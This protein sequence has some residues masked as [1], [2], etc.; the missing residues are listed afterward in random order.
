MVN[1]LKDPGLPKPQ[2]VFEPIQ[3]NWSTQ[4]SIEGR[5]TYTDLGYRGKAP[6]NTDKPAIVVRTGYG[7]IAA[8]FILKENISKEEWPE[9]ALDAMARPETNRNGAHRQIYGDLSKT[10][11]YPFPLL[12]PKLY[13]E[14]IYETTKLTC[15]AIPI[16]Q[17]RKDGVA[18]TKGTPCK[19]GDQITYSLC[20]SMPCNCFAAQRVHKDVKELE[21]YAP[22][23][24]SFEMAKDFEPPG[25]R[26]KAKELEQLQRQ[27]RSAAAK[28]GWETR[29]RKAAET[30]AEAA[31]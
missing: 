23:R 31:Q 16:C 1:L 15:E 11:E 14:D 8:T 19:P 30:A 25:T 3:H 26:D 28:K 10:S 9:V 18:G 27:R 13:K 7:E 20:A 12:K 5:G 4:I 2:E 21:Q 22:T 24:Q 6:S 17:K 29:R